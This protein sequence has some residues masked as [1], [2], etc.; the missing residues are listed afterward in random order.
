MHNQNVITPRRSSR[1]PAAIPVLVTSLDPKTHFSEVCETLVVSAHG[2]AVRSRMKLETGVQLHLHSKDGRDTTAQV[3]SCLPLGPGSQGWK[4]GARLDRPENFWGL[5]NSPKDWPVFHLSAPPSSAV[6]ATKSSYQTHGELSQSSELV[7]ADDVPESMSEENVNRMIAAS[8]RTLQEEV[9]EL[10]EKL[11]RRET[12]RSRFEVSLSSIPPELEEQLELRLRQHLAPRIVDEARQQSTQLL[13][14]AKATLDQRTSEA[15]QDFLRQVAK[16]ILTVKQRVQDASAHILESVREQTRGSLGEFQQNLIDGG[17]RLKKLSEELLEFMQQSLNEE[18]EARRG[19]LGEIRA[20]VASESLRLHEHVE[21]L[22]GRIAKLN[23]SACCLESG[24]DKR[25][26]QMASDRI[27]ST[28]TELESAAD[29]ILKDA[30]TR[31]LQALGNQFDEACEKMKTLEKEIVKSVSESLNCHATEASRAFEQST[32][33][34][35]RHSLEHLRHRLTVS[36]NALLK[37]LS[38]QLDA[39]AEHAG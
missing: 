37:N 26:G 19:E 34:A 8:V 20:A 10:K 31:N 4:L 32:G 28:R 21:L 7:L 18:H 24:L 12:N 13:S 38:E 11:A 39:N 22:D 35:A 15:Y 27:R 5:L 3:V 16:E 14:A 6:V 9:A 36:L 17:N 25:L 2:C 29:T 1:I 33:D 23:E 30:A